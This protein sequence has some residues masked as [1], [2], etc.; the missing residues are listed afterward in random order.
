MSFK[1]PAYLKKPTPVMKAPRGLLR[2]PRRKFNAHE[3]LPLQHRHQQEK[4]L[5]RDAQY[6]EPQLN[7]MVL[8][9]KPE[10]QRRGAGGALVQWGIDKAKQDGLT[11]TLFS[12]P[13]GYGL[14]KKLGFADVGWPAYRLKG[15]IW[16]LH[17]R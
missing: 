5:R 12:S 1:P 8:A 15:R 7:L 16:C 11:V 3:S 2:P 14:Y 6:A 13:Q 9:T 10:Y 17:F 4:G